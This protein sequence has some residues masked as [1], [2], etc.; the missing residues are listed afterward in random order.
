MREADNGIEHDEAEASR[1]RRR[2]LT[3][4]KACAASV[5]AAILLAAAPFI[6]PRRREVW[7]YTCRFCAATKAKRTTR[8]AGV[9]VRHSET[10]PSRTALREVYDE[11]IAE[12][13][14]HQWAGGPYTGWDGNLLRYKSHGHGSHNDSRYS[15]YQWFLTR[16]ALCVI[17]LL[18]DT[19]IEF[20]RQVYHGLIEIDNQTEFDEAM[21]VYDKTR[22]DPPS[23]AEQWQR[24]LAKRTGKQ[25]SARQRAD[26][27]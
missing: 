9:V 24:W 26:H 12:P 13:H 21:R 14:D 23:A 2:W 1:V 10:P 7:I 25:Q 17:S 6:I 16:T 4:R 5:V 11:V 20:R 18:S 27:K 15:K 22:R 3:P 8:I 19:P